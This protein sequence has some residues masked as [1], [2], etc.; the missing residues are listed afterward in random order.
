M[1]VRSPHITD[2]TQLPLV[3]TIDEM[4]SIYRRARST[5]RR[6]LQRRRFQPK[7]FAGPPYRW[8]RADVEQD[9]RRRQAPAGT[10]RRARPPSR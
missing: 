4:A 10:S 9:L 2:L 3:L 1:M 8:L 7:P 5:I 6:D